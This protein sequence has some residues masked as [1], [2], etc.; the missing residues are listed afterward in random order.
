ML[1]RK[2]SQSAAVESAEESVRSTTG[3]ST[4]TKESWPAAPDARTTSQHL[5]PTEA[6]TKA[7]IKD[8]EEDVIAP[9]VEK[10][11]QTSLEPRPV[12]PFF[13]KALGSTIPFSLAKE[14]I[15]PSTEVI[16]I[17]DDDRTTRADVASV[18]LLA[19]EG[20]SR[21]HPLAVESRPLKPLRVDKAAS[22]KPLAPLFAPRRPKGVPAQLRFASPEIV[23]L[24]SM[25][26]EAASDNPKPGSNFAPRTSKAK[27]ETIPGLSTS[28]TVLKAIEE[29]APFPTRDLQHVRGLQHVFQTASI[30]YRP[31]AKHASSSTFHP[32]TG[33]LREM[34]WEDSSSPPFVESLASSTSTHV[35]N[36]SYLRAIPE[37]H[38]QHPAISPSRLAFQSEGSRHFLWVDKWRPNRA[39]EV[40]GNEGSAIYLRDWIRALELNLET[41]EGATAS[42]S[43][44]NS[45]KKTNASAGLSRGTKRNR[46]IVREANKKLGRK[47]RRVNSDD[48]SEDNWIIDDSEYTSSPAPSSPIIDTPPASLRPTFQQE[49][50]AHETFPLLTNTILLSGPSG[51]GKT[52]AVYACARELGWDVLEVYPGIGRRN[53]AGIDSLIGDAGKNHHVRKARHG[54]LRSSEPASTFFTG[55]KKSNDL[56]SDDEG[57]EPGPTNIGPPSTIMGDALPK[58]HS[59][60]QS[61]ILLEEVDI[62]FKEDANFWPA[63]INFIRECRRPVICTCNVPT[64]DLPLQ[65]ILS[66]EP[67]EPQLAVSYLQAICSHEGPYWI[68]RDAL[69]QLYEDSA[70]DV[71]SIDMPDIPN[72]AI[73]NDFPVPDLRRTIN[74]LQFL[75]A[76]ASRNSE[77]QLRLDKG[78]EDD[79]CNL[80]EISSIWSADQSSLSSA[81]IETRKFAL[82]TRHADHLSFMDTYLTRGPWDTRE[83]LA[84]ISCE[85]SK[86]DEVGH[87]ILFHPQASTSELMWA[88]LYS[89]DTEMAAAV[90]RIARGGDKSTRGPMSAC[91]TPCRTRELFRARVDHEIEITKA[92]GVMVPSVTMSMRRKEVHLDYMT[93][94]R[95]IVAA[96]DYAAIMYT[97]RHISGRQTKNSARKYERI[98][99]VSEEERIALGRT[100][101][102]K[103]L[104]LST[105]LSPPPLAPLQYLQNQRR[106]SITDPSLHT[107]SNIKLNTAYRPG[108]EQPSSASSGASSAQQDMRP[109]SPY[110]FGHATPHGGA[111]MAIRNLLRSS[112]EGPGPKD[113]AMDTDG[114]FD[115]TMRRHSIPVGQGQDK[116]LGLGTKR[117]MGEEVLAGPGM[118]SDEGPAPKRRSSAVDTARI[119]Q[120]SLNDRFNDRRHSVDLWLGSERRDSTSSFS[121]VLT[122]ADSPKSRQATAFVWP[123]PEMPDQKEQDDPTPPLP[124]TASN[125][126]KDSATPYSRSPE[127]RVSHKLAERKRRKEMKDLF[128]ELRDQLP[129]DRGMKASKWEILSKAIEFVIQLKQSHQEMARELE[130][131][132]HELDATRQAQGLPFVYGQPSMPG[133]FPPGAHPPQLPQSRP[134]S[135]Q[136]LNPGQPLT[137][138]APSMALLFHPKKPK[139]K[140]S[141]SPAPAPSPSPR[142]STNGK[143]KPKPPPAQTEDDGLQLPTGPFQEFKLM[144]SALNGWKYDIMKFDS[145]KS[146]D[147]SRWQVPIK[148]NRKELRRDDGV[149]DAAPQAV[150]PMLGPDGKPVIGVD[151]KMVMVDAEGRPIHATDGASGSNANGKGKAPAA[152]GKK[153]FQKKTRQVYVVPDEVRQLRRE[154]RYPWVMEDSSPN[155]DEVW[156]AQMEDV[157]KSETYALFMPAVN[158]IFKFVPTHRWYKFQKKMKHDLPTDTANVESMYTQ[159]QKRGDAWLASRR[160]VSAATAAMFKAESE[161]RSIG[162]GLVHSSGQ[163]LGPGG[164][165]LKTV[166]S[167]MSG[168]F[169]DDDDADAKRRREKELGEE[170]DLDEQVYEEDFADDEEQMEVDADDEEAKELEERL[171][172]EYKAANKQ[173]EAGVDESDDEIPIPGMTKQA[174]AMQKLIRNREG[175]DAY[176]SDEE[177]NPYASSVEEEEEEPVVATGPAVQQQPQQVDS[178]SSSQTPKPGPA[179]VPA[180]PANGTNS[181]AVS[182]VASPSLGGHSVVAKRAT[183][184]KPPKPKAPVN[185]GTSPLGSRAT[186]PVASNS[187]ATSPAAGGSSVG[188]PITSKPN[189]KRKALDEPANIGA[190]ATNGAHGAQMPKAKKRKAQGVVPINATPEQLKVMLIEWLGSTQSATTR[191]CI[192]H[193]TPYLTDAEK[194]TQFSSL[195]RDVAQLKDGVLVLRKKFQEGGSS[196]PSPMP[197]G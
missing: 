20:G 101:L 187:R 65:T 140:D 10:F 191:E 37:L 99:E 184:P 77:L 11:R 188:S 47:K 158:D 174:K 24:E 50:S 194:K 181:R 87:V 195:V 147:L 14:S 21:K 163:S 193:F 152:N 90:M 192:H 26:H 135:A 60:R 44:C 151:G 93:S 117:K 78:D 5:T 125:H 73:P 7:V 107:A 2:P 55:D 144:S 74:G 153:R 171:K 84:W 61:L 89:Q 12:H 97:Q 123:T 126:R 23:M 68:N 148:L 165:K 30:P 33:S 1:A 179:V 57:V 88:G 137:L 115:Y 145:R 52:A 157:I 16:E 62:L 182:P 109:I 154:E 141:E 72:P 43:S 160:N 111:E 138:S 86:D 132:R 128:D 121:S 177:E 110:V 34:N 96:E 46:T 85:P 133:P 53:G 167:G 35:D 168:L 129:A 197:V 170:G 82:A 59:V 64:Q 70:H 143:A 155:K 134:P 118:P 69:L 196:A 139:K 76:S 166:D 41:N 54:T 104:L 185:G 136:N 9:V 32:E 183:S 27:A 156:T 38:R 40:L 95:D 63:V 79:M 186:S 172:R 130:I 142:K 113:K 66:F 19:I 8:R 164:R 28:R 106:G 102:S 114:G 36:N 18:E 48:E 189:N 112:P 124:S 105:R 103:D 25:D 161:G 4:S 98:I 159:Q 6:L 80:G 108:I 131:L 75:C 49:P 122:P 51:L 31:R 15:Q 146:V 116:G 120:L 22:L 17:L 58:T 13:I 175:N 180:R 92:L 176:D 119:A 81:T 29:K 190:P 45:G 100:V 150:G 173:R 91:T 127:L 162:G 56:P 178:R 83:G 169:D 67:C 149:V 42:Q 94:V 39:E 71:E 3:A